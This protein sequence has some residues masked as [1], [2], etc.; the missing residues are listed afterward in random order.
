VG[1]SRFKRMFRRDSKG[2][3]RKGRV[4]TFYKLPK[5]IKTLTDLF[6]CSYWM[7][8]RPRNCVLRTLDYKKDLDKVVKMWRRVVGV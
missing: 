8:T 5:V 6:T 1:K 2:R 4:V 7:G 3:F